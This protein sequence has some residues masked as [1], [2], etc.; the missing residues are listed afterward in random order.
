MR[1]EVAWSDRVPERD[2]VTPCVYDMAFRP[3]GSQ[4][5]CAVGSRVLVYNAADGQLLHSLKGHKDTL[6]CVAYSRDGKRFASGGAD[7]T[8]I[9]WTAKA[10]GI[11]KY[12]HNDSVQCL[13]YN[14]VTQQLASATATD[15]GLWSPEQKSVAKHKVTSRVMCMSWTNDGTCLALGHFTGQISLRDKS[16]V[17]RLAIQRNAPVWAIQWNPSRDE[18]QDLLAV[19]CWDQ[20]LSFYELSGMQHGNDRQLGF[21]PWCAHPP[22]RDPGLALPRAARFRLSARLAQLRAPLLERRV[23]VHR[24]LRPKGVAVDKGAPVSRPPPA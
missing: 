20:T 16:G 21:D 9:I 1:T 4:I 18:S 7:K 12:S 8:I 24:R 2:G 6:Y 19:A 3:D 10:E 15:F 14:S 22:P 17:E 11:L 13:C 5:V 23:P